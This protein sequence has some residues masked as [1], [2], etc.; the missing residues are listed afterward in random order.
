M[1]PRE[2]ARGRR[3]VARLRH[4]GDLHEEITAVAEAYGMKPD[5]RI[6]VESAVGRAT[7]S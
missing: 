6:V 4:G 2:Y 1:G 7:R 3:V 5:D